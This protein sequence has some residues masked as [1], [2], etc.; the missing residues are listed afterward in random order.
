VVQISLVCGHHQ[1][2]GIHTPDKCMI[3]AGFRVL[4]GE[5][6][7]AEMVDTP[8]GTMRVRTAQFIKDHATGVINQRMMWTF[9][10]NGEWEASELGRASLAGQPGWFK[11]YVTTVAAGNNVQDTSESRGFLEQ[12]IPRLNDALFPKSETP[13][14]A[15]KSAS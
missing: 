12:F 4:D 2:I 11:L 3:G 5:S 10:H 6:E 14:A 8:R 9:S 1:T 15:E 7:R 13:A